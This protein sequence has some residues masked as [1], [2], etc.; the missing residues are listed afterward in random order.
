MLKAIKE[1]FF[2]KQSQTDQAN[3]APYKV[4][5]TPMP[6]PQPVPTVFV[7]GHGDAREVV[8]PTVVPPVAEPVK[9]GCGRSATGYCVGLH[10]LSQEEWATHPDNPTK[11]AAKVK[12]AAKI[13]AKPKNPK[14]K[15]PATKKPRT[16]KP[17][18]EK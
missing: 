7:D 13:R 15:A 14:P 6:E 5:V 16:K 1:F 4:E 17:T 11:P 8:K 18:V 3:Q 9:C 10:K 2:G 12:S